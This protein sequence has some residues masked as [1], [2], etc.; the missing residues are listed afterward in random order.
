MRHCRSTYRDRAAVSI[1]RVRRP[2]NGQDPMCCGSHG[3]RSD[4]LA[5]RTYMSSN[6][7]KRN[8]FMRNCLVH[9]G[10]EGGTSR[11]SREEEGHQ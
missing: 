1:R 7:H 11:V 5:N 2:S 6:F 3:H 8:G 9:R 4:S 10:V